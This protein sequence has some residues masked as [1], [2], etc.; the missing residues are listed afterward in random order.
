MF[1]HHVSKNLGA[2]TVLVTISGDPKTLH[3]TE[4]VSVVVDT[5]VPDEVGG[6]TAGGYSR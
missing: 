6:F 2:Q 3:K 1:L 4:C 5:V